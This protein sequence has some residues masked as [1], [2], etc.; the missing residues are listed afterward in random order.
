MAHHGYGETGRRAGGA[1]ARSHGNA[2]T[3]G[4]DGPRKLKGKATR[5]TFAAGARRGNPLLAASSR[6]ATL[7]LVSISGYRR[8]DASRLRGGA[9]RAAALDPPWIAL[10]PRSHR[11]LAEELGAQL[12]D[13]PV[14]RLGVVILLEVEEALHPGRAAVTG[15]ICGDRHR[16]CPSSF[17]PVRS[18]R[19]FRQLWTGVE[20]GFSYLKG[21]FGLRRCN[22]RHWSASKPYVWSAI[23]THNLV[24]PR[25]TQA[26]TQAGVV[27]GPAGSR[28]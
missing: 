5:A 16:Q 13:L 24:G 6:R 15:P 17:S 7:R 20:A 27:P 19:R 11:D 10:E 1:Q 8:P 4:L 14:E 18:P 9:S 23:V 28:D 2:I 12:A 3:A 21:R 26:E 25:S 22:W